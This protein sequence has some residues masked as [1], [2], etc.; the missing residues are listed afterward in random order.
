MFTRQQE[1]KRA[2]VSGGDLRGGADSRRQTNT[3]RKEG[4][5]KGLE[6]CTRVSEYVSACVWERE[7]E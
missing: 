1:G 3:K 2:K 5:E 6:E 4:E 7:R